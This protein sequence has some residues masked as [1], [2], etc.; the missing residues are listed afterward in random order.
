MLSLSEQNFIIPFWHI[1]YEPVFESSWSVQYL[2]YITLYE[3]QG[4]GPELEAL[5]HEPGHQCH[6]IRSPQ[7]L[8]T[9]NTY[10]ASWSRGNFVN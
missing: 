5:A 6:N 9:C 1:Q 8:H 3:C 2:Q 10:I 7:L 4:S